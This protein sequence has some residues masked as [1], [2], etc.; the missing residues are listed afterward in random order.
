[1]GII[2]AA[3][4]CA[5][6]YVVVRVTLF[7]YRL[8]SPVKID[9]KKFGSW[10]VVTGSTDGIGL[11]YATH[12]YS[13]IRDQIRGL[14]IGILVN[15]VG[16]SYDYPE[17]F[18]KVENSESFMNK[19]LRCNVDSVSQ[20]THMILPDLIKKRNGLIVNVSSISGRYP[21]PLL[22]LYSG[23]KAFVDFFSRSL[24]VECANRGVLVQSLCPGFVCSKLSGI[25]KPSLF[26][27]TAE[28]YAIS[29]LERVALPYTTGFWAHEIQMSFI[30]VTQDSHFP[31]Q[32]LPYGVF[33]TN[34]NSRHRIG[35]AIGKYIVDLSQIKHLFNGPVMKDK[36]SVFD[37]PV[38]NE[39]MALDSKAW[40]EVRSYLQKLLAFVEQKDAIMHL[41]AQIGDYTDF[42]ASKQHATNVGTMFRGKDNALNPNWLHLP[43]GYHGRASSVVISGTPIRRPNG[44]KMAFFVGKGN[45]MGRP[46]TINEADEHIFGLVIMNDWSARDIQK[47]E[48]VPLGPFNGKNFGTTLSP[49]IVPMEALK[50]AL[51]PSELQDP[52]PL[53]YLRENDR[54]SLNIDLE[55][56]LKADKCNE[57]W[58]ICRS[59][60]KNIYWSLKQMLV[61]HT[62]T[63]CNMKPGDLI[64]TGTISG[65]TP[66][67]YGSMLELS[68]RGTKPLEL[69][70]DVQ[71]KF[72]E[73]GDTIIMTGCYKGDGFNIGFGECSGTV[74]PALSIPT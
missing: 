51:C 50:D 69:T 12:I 1:M 30:E 10:A 60:S 49:W 33:S 71:R 8:L 72:L 36:Q 64:A 28:Q 31:I 62:M 14:D 5:V 9:V 58:T 26:T 42:Y 48:Y 15:N 7:L 56:R 73:D 66:E 74:L 43:I 65:S 54:S 68:W 34:D 2:T 35:V 4:V 23:T 16:M 11:A 52:E 67:S 22:A 6:L 44:Q 59:N 55:V 21:V 61:Q 40:K 57:T 70:K 13:T 3:G 29:A 32:N 45:E 39:F 37:Q 25:R 18:D 19:M 20:M 41:P 17:V 27:P 46:I 47:W 63:G 53:P 38:L 24:A